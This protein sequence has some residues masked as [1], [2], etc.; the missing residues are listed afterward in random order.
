MT[1]GYGEA[2]FPSIV[3]LA[4]GWLIAAYQVGYGLAALGAGALQHVLSLSVVFRIAAAAAA[5][6]GL[7]ALV[8]ARGQ[9]QSPPSPMASVSAT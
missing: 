5:G 4:A 6:M 3:E 1:V 2:T 9:R 7:L 8:I